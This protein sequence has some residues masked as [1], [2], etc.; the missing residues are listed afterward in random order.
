[1]FCGKMSL[2]Q[3]VS[4]A[5]SPL[6]HHHHHDHHYQRIPGCWKC[7][8]MSNTTPCVI[9]RAPLPRPQ[10]LFFIIGN[11]R[12]AFF[13]LFPRENFVRITCSQNLL[14][15][16]QF[17]SKQYFS[18]QDLQRQLE[19]SDRRPFEEEVPVSGPAGPAKTLNL[20]DCTKLFFTCR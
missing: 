2:G 20:S 1:M 7:S 13:F 6:A 14:N 11:S 12:K 5:K 10:I 3:N 19:D 4:G 17:T 9:L 18:H 15:T 8:W 16:A